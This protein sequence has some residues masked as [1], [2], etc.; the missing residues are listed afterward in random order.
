MLAAESLAISL[1][2]A[3]VGCALAWLL[4]HLAAG[5]QMGGAMPLYIQL[6]ALTVMLALGVAA[7]ISL[8]ST[9]LPAY[10]ASRINIA[11]ALRFVG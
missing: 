6:D 1:G 5:Y 4:L 10:R 11:Q 9:L 7:G 3:L 8:A 2:G